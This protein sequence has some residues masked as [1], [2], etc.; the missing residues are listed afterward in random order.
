MNFNNSETKINLMRAFAGECQAR[1]R[2]VFYASRA[3]TQG[4]QVIAHL[5][6]FVAEQEKEHAEV[7]YKALK[8]VTGEKILIKNADYPVE[9]FNDVVVMLR[10][11]LE[12]ELEESDVIYK[13]FGEIAGEEGFVDVAD[14]FFLISKI[15]RLHAARFKVFAELIEEQKMF[16]SAQISRWICLKCGN[17]HQGNEVP[18][19]CQVC[20]HNFGFF[21]K[22]EDF[23]FVNQV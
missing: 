12:N 19:E 22:D 7:F 4:L 6:S 5:F 2:Y 16:K 10:K 17:V 8:P 21:L 23:L 20:G 3:K 18:K 11:S 14:K 9:L 15:E 13:K 1:M